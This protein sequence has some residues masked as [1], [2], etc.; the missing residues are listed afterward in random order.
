MFCPWSNWWADFLFLCFWSLTSWIGSQWKHIA[1]SSCFCHQRAP[2]RH[3][4]HS[5][6]NIEISQ[7]DTTTGNSWYLFFMIKTKH[8]E[9]QVWHQLQ[10]ESLMI[11]APPQTQQA[12][13]G[14][15]LSCAAQWK[16]DVDKQAEPHS[17]LCRFKQSEERGAAQLSVRP[18]QLTFCDNN[19]NYYQLVWW[20]LSLCIDSLFSL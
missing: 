11:S 14:E 13:G 17:T 2:Q 15:F 12:A 16:P 7:R 5:T 10:S 4:T 3:F 18:Q 9:H 19:K 1:C 8:S 20:S 6:F